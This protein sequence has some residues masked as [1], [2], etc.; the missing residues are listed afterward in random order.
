MLN[1]RKKLVEEEVPEAPEGA[2]KKTSNETVVALIAGALKQFGNDVELDGD[3]I[4]VQ[5]YYGKELGKLNVDA[6]KDLK[7]GSKLV[8]LTLNGKPCVAVVS[9]EKA[10]ANITDIQDKLA[11]IAREEMKKNSFDAAL[12]SVDTFGFPLMEDIESGNEGYQT[13]NN[14]LEKPKTKVGSEYDEKDL[15]SKEVVPGE[16]K[17]KPQVAQAQGKG[18]GDD[19][20]D[21]D[22]KKIKPTEPDEKPK[23]V[24]E[25]R[26]LQEGAKEPSK[27]YLEKLTKGFMDELSEIGGESASMDSDLVH[28]LA[29]TYA[30]ELSAN[31]KGYDTS[32][33][34]N[35][36]LKKA[37][38]SVKE[39]AIQEG[40][41]ETKRAEDWLNGKSAGSAPD[42]FWSEGDLAYSYNTVIA[43]KTGK[44]VYV[45]TTK[46]SNTTS[47]IVS[48]LKGAAKSAGLKVV[49]KDESYFDTSMPIKLGVG[50]KVEGKSITKAQLED[51]RKRRIARLAEAKKL[52]EGIEDGN[53]GIAD[54]SNPLEKPKTKVGTEYDEKDLPKN[55]V[56]PDPIDNSGLGDA[57]EAQGTGKGD[58]EKDLEKSKIK[59]V[60]SPDQKLKVVGESRNVLE[61]MKKRVKAKI[62]E[63]MK[64]KKKVIKK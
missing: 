22:K 8:E 3:S 20:K 17:D 37:G 23:V 19:E 26:R 62:S 9:I 10:K 34:L 7:D 45:N 63:K 2:P 18:E 49:E 32:K 51:I 29:K 48:G 41:K 64:A 54:A 58:K 33:F 36:L 38:Y 56:V 57:A 47:K 28:D 1:F 53:E 21:L 24:G 4:E 44:V 59:T 50:G 30:S 27:A 11:E 13:A 12:E 43:K 25:S 46:Y 35:S 39:G 55:E 42:A 52:K 14:P 6:V 40:A 61:E 15:A 5:D 60:D 31:F 16:P